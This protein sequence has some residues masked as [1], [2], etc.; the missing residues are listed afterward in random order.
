M[1]MVDMKR[2]PEEKATRE[3]EMSAGVSPSDDEYPYSTRLQL[4]RDELD[5]L[6]ITD[7]PAIGDEF[8]IEAVAKVISARLEAGEN[9]DDS[10][11][12][13][14]QITK[15]GCEP[16]KKAKTAA[17]QLYGGETDGGEA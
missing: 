1:K 8:K 15:L 14:L 12:V 7:L 17:A 6:G 2:T 9:D 3:K 10:R 13:E 5:K 11:S 4:G 16:A